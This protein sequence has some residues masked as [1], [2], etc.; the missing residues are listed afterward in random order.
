MAF[1]TV[2]LPIPRPPPLHSSTLTPADGATTGK[3][4]NY[5]RNRITDR[6]DSTIASAGTTPKAYWTAVLSKNAIQKGRRLPAVRGAVVHNCEKTTRGYRA[7]RSSS[8]STK[9]GAPPQAS[10]HLIPVGED[11]K[12]NDESL[13]VDVRGFKK[14]YEEDGE[15]YLDEQKGHRE[16][17]R[18]MARKSGLVAVPPHKQAIKTR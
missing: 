16:M 14:C 8:T 6:F 1:S 13:G 4:R 18:F 3:R 10:G 5:R 2:T 12:G 17:A 9:V 15:M 11:D 7:N